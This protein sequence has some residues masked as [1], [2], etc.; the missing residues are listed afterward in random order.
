VQSK[1][2]LRRDLRRARREHVSALPPAV[3]R[4]VFN[5]PPAVIGDLLK[6]YPVVGL[7]HAAGSEAPTLGWI[8]WL[9]ENGWRIALPWFAGRDA[10]MAFRGW[11]D[12]WNEDLLEPAPWGGLQPSAPAAPLLQP[13]ALVVPLVGFTADGHRLGQGGG[14]YDRW[15]AAHPQ[16]PAIGL[17]WDVQRV[18]NLPLE[19]HDHPLVAVVTPTQIF[20]SAE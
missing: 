7:Y 19:P 14:H 2:E 10:P 20:R 13:E 11:T 12:P 17:A 15:L 4:L 5:R 6:P 9:H 18:E 16:T 3:S 1:A 8:R